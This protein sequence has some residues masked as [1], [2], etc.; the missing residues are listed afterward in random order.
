M[1]DRAAERRE[2]LA[3]AQP[4][5]CVPVARVFPSDRLTPVMLF[6]PHARRGRRVLPARERRGRRDGG[7]L[8]VPRVRARRAA[9]RSSGRQASRSSGAGSSSRA[10]GRSSRRRSSASSGGERFVPDPDLPPLAAGA[11]GYLGYDAVRLFEEIPDRHP[12]DG[13][14]S[15]RAVSPLRRRRRV[16]PSAA[17]SPP[18]DDARPDG[19]GRRRTRGRTARSR[20]STG[21]R[22]F[23]SRAGSGPARRGR[24]RGAVRAGHAAASAYLDAVG[25]RQ[26]SDR[27]RR[28]LPVRPLAALDGPRSDVDPFDVYRALRALNPVALPLLPRDAGGERARRVARDARALPRAARSRRGRSRARRRAARRRRRTHGWPRRCWPTRRS[29]PST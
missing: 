17:A 25:A 1:R 20:G 23:S 8:H 9:G 12:R 5:A 3:R 7:A 29:A 11:V 27:G 18:A 28:R 14:D 4:G 2:F 6:S 15:G 22:R 26:G 13:R 16:R 24:R 19:R 21:S 10:P